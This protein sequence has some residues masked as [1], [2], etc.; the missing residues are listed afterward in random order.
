MTA[1]TALTELAVT[2][3]NLWGESVMDDSAINHRASCPVP[4]GAA[5]DAAI[6]EARAALLRAPGGPGQSGRVLP[7][8]LALS[9]G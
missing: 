4:D 9:E 2:W 1:A 7:A 6:D 5:L 8:G 3:Q